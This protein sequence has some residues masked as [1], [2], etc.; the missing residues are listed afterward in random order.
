MPNTDLAGT[1]LIDQIEFISLL[2]IG[3]MARVYKA[4]QILLDRIVAVKVLSNRGLASDVTLK[5]FQSEATLTS[6]LSHPNIVRI[7][8]NGVSAD[9]QPYL[10]ME[11]VEGSSLADEINNHAPLTYRRFRDIFLPLLRALEHAHDKGILHRDIKPSNIIVTR[12]ENAKDVPKLADFGIAKMFDEPAAGSA[13]EKGL[14]KTGVVVGS[15]K[16]M[17]PEQC[18]GK[19]L[20]A[21]SD[22]YSLACVMYEA[23]SGEP[24]FCADSDI[25]LMY[26]HVNETRPST[27]ELSVRME[28]PQKLARLI[29]W[30]LNK[31]LERRPKSAGELHSELAAVLDELTLDN[32]PHKTDRSS[33]RGRNLTPSACVAAGAIILISFLCVSQLLKPH[34][35]PESHV[36][37]ESKCGKL[38]EQ[39][40]KL[41][42]VRHREPDAFQLYQEAI[43][44]IASRSLLNETLVSTVLCG[45][46]LL[47]AH[48]EI[49]SQLL[50]Y[51]DRSIDLSKQEKDWDH[52][53]TMVNTKARI[54]QEM[55]SPDLADAFTND[56]LK[57]M[58]KSHSQRNIL[59]AV[60]VR[61]TALVAADKYKEAAELC[62]RFAQIPLSSECGHDL[63]FV[64]E[65][66]LIYSQPANLRVANRVAHAKYIGEKILDST[67]EAGTR[68]QLLAS[69]ESIL[70]SVDPPGYF[71]LI[72]TEIKRNRELYSEN[73]ELYLE[74]EVL[75]ANAYRGT[76]RVADAKIQYL[77]ILVRAEKMGSTSGSAACLD[78][79]KGLIELSAKD[80]ANK[81]KYQEQLNELVRQQR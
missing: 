5:R 23:M 64:Q 44:K 17:S 59:A 12:D 18:A 2:G 34:N 22:L 15:P 56:I 31:D 52:F 6:S 16:Y 37:E 57:A 30:G 77:D 19:E 71:K 35:S 58:E 11:F 67:F 43:P 63:F 60:R 25:D 55:H 48:P 66:Y 4:R 14:T 26:K 27:K 74:L 46:N 32:T 20:D 80:P 41:Y 36:M 47:N 61:A 51:A 81:R 75:Q 70:L 65:M 28:I 49:G 76:R 33:R 3:G 42:Y 13:N 7:F 40:N 78:C 8:A 69:L 24:V 73:P 1:P 50:K 9:G 38:I 72:T 29:L 10:V 39:A 62:K 53:F 21:R 79:L 68:I 54:L 45:H